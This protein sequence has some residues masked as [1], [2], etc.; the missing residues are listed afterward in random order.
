MVS[1]AYFGDM[2]PHSA[3]L[4][5]SVSKSLVG[6]VAGS[7]CDS[8]LLDPTA[9]LTDYLPALTGTGYAGATV[10]NLLDM[11]SGIGFSE[12]YLDPRA[13]VRMMEEAIG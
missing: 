13:E 10:R 4:V 5:M 3:H 2:A 12:D 6:A 11:R 8:G 7:L 9:P 1:E